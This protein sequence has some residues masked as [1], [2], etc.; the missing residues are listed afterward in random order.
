[1]APD[2]NEIKKVFY[3][4][5]LLKL[6]LDYFLLDF[7]DSGPAFYRDK[8]TFKKMGSGYLIKGESKLHREIQK[9]YLLWILHA[10]NSFKS[11]FS[12]KKSESDLTHIENYISKILNKK[13]EFTIEIE[14]NLRHWLARE[15]KEY[16]VYLSIPEIIKYCSKRV[17]KDYMIL[18]PKSRF[19]IK[20]I[21]RKGENKYLKQIIINPEVEGKQIV[22]FSK[23]PVSKM[24]EN[25]MKKL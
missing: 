3:K 14:K 9:H 2:K 24:N 17:D 11:R 16:Y 6:F 25:S 13:H 4:T 10:K 19:D 7:I 15:G 1:M 12:L 8:F 22:S 20:K 23:T 5:K 21:I 18:S